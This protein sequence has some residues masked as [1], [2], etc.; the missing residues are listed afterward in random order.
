MNFHLLRPLV[1]IASLWIA[2]PATAD[3]GAAQA[4]YNSGEFDNAANLA[5]PLAEAGD[6]A[7]LNLLG[8]MHHY[9]HGMAEDD[10]KAF[11]LFRRAADGG[12]AAAQ[13]NLANM[14]MYGYGIPEGTEEPEREAVRL[15]IDAALG[16]NAD[17]QYTLGLMLLAGSVVVQDPEEAMVWIQRAAAQGH[18]AAQDYVDSNSGS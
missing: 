5:A 17:A 12:L 7:A 1:L 13:Y 3:F 8:L 11:D 2:A 18:E 10:G 6:P 15:Y 9:G 4:A 16:G 14:Y